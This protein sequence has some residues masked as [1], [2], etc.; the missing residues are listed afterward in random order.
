MSQQPPQPRRP[1]RPSA[2]SEGRAGAGCLSLLLLPWLASSLFGGFVSAGAPLIDGLAGVFSGG[3]SLVLLVPIVGLLGSLVWSGFRRASGHDERVSFVSSGG[4]ALAASLVLLFVVS[5]LLAAFN[6]AAG[7][8]AGAAVGSP[9]LLVAAALVF[10][11]STSVVVFQKM[12]AQRKVVAERKQHQGRPR[13]PWSNPLARTEPANMLVEAVLN[14]WN[15]IGALAA[16]ALSILMANPL[17][18]LV[19]GGLELF[20]LAL[21]PDTKWFAQSVDA[22]HRALAEEQATERR[23][24]QLEYLNEEQRALHDQMV[25]IGDGARNALQA[26]NYPFDVAKIDRI[27]DHHLWLMELENY[28]GDMDDTHRLAEL[29]RQLTDAQRQADDSTGRMADV[30]EQRVHVLERRIDQLRRLSEHVD[31]IRHQR[32]GLEDA[33]RLLSESALSAGA[34]SSDE[35]DAV[36]EHLEITEEVVLDFHSE[37]EE[38]DAAIEEA[39]AK[40]GIAA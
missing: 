22:K 28:Y 3:V 38:L 32:T 9:G 27:V 2:D 20:Y 37:E 33:L 25:A 39:V 7:A 35:I 10:L 5:T 36:L 23:D 16:A 21:V 19:F 17:P 1:V 8:I 30:S 18:A 31:Q 40:A 4:A 12:R 34:T 14:Q 11:A 29:D 13:P 15:L 26:S 6:S 24:E